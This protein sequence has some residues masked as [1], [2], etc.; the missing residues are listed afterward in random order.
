MLVVI[1]PYYRSLEAGERTASLA[2]E[3]EIPNIFMVANKVKTDADKAAIDQFCQKHD[4]PIIG[5]IPLEEKFMEAERQETAPIDF[6]SKSPG[7]MAIYDI[8][9]KLAKLG[10]RTHPPKPIPDHF[11]LFA[12]GYAEGKRAMKYNKE[13]NGA[14]DKEAIHESK[15]DK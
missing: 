7:A 4:L 2:K 14:Y 9:L 5:Y 12:K 10:T 8:S 13:K 1:E 6:D 11:S 15:N 3:L